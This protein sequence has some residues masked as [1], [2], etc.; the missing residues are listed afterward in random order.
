[1]IDWVARKL[2]IAWSP[3]LAGLGLDPYREQWRWVA[4]IK[5]MMAR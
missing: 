3:S 2:G 1:M 4:W 5:R